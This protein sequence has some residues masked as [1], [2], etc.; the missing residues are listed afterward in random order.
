MICCRRFSSIGSSG[1][2]FGNFFA[3]KRRDPH[4]TAMSS[5]KKMLIKPALASGGRQAVPTTAKKQAKQKG[6]RRTC[7]SK[8][9]CVRQELEVNI[10]DR[11]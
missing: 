5:T 9:R 2:G 1:T 8:E 4:S 11:K 3:V 7:N 6:K 10:H